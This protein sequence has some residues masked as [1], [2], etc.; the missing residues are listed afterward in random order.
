M[1]VI[2]VT[3]RTTTPPE[4]IWK[5][6]ADVPNR[7]SWDV[8]LE[9]AKLEDPFQS[10]AIGRIKLKGQPERNFE[11]L[12]CI[13]LQKYTDRFF[14]PMGGKMDWVHSITKAGDDY[15]ITF[16]V[17]VF[18]PTSLMLA[19]IMKSVL[20]EVLPATVEKLVSLAEVGQFPPMTNGRTN[21]KEAR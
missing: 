9:Y 8:S 7:T 5:L 6:W 19:L 14:L 3:R 2:T 16:V 13:P 12:D 17:S 11:I 15:M 21:Q 1:H 20:R 18:G 4:N 10:D